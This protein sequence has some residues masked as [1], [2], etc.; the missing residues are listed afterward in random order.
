MTREEALFNVSDRGKGLI[1][2][3]N[4][5]YDDFESRTCDNC[6]NKPKENENYPYEC[7]TCSR[8]YADSYNLNK[9]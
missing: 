3:V 4:E 9:L 2:M 5:I 1:R 8:F 6:T 7:G